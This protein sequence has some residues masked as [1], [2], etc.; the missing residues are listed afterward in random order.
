MIAF[1][2]VSIYNWDVMKVKNIRIRRMRIITLLFVEYRMRIPNTN[3]N[4][5]ECRK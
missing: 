2:Y 3:T 1:I 5:Q 4:Y